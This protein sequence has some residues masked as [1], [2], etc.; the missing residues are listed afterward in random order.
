MII[1]LLVFASLYYAI[2]FARQELV[3]RRNAFRGEVL[4]VTAHPDDECMFFAPTLRELTQREI[5]VHILCLSTGN[6]DGLGVKRA[7]EFKASCAVMGITNCMVAD[8]EKLRDGPSKWQAKDI[9]HVLT[10]KLRH[11]PAVRTIMTFDKNGISGHP[12]HCDVSTGVRY[13][14]M[15]SSDEYHLMELITLPW[16]LKY[17]GPLMVIYECIQSGLVSNPTSRYISVI[18]W[19]EYFRYGIRAMIQHR[20]QLVWFRWLYLLASSYMHINTLY[21]HKPKTVDK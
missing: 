7:L 13:F 20:T 15:H 8:E 9:A 18:P 6:Y 11:L 16:F 21:M 19:N 17:L 5:P 3:K 2:E 14:A 12:N 1:V 4:L 10:D